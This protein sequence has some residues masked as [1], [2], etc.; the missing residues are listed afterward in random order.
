[1]IWLGLSAV[2]RERMFR[3]PGTL[4]HTVVGE[5]MIRAGEVIR[6][7]P[8]SFTFEG[9]TWIAHQWLAECAMALAH[10]AAGLDGLLLV[11]CVILAATYAAVGQRLIRGGMSFAGS[12]AVI[13]LLLGAS[14]F[15]FHARPHILTIAFSAWIFALLCDV[16]AG[17]RKLQSMWAMPLI[18]GLWANL[19]GGALGGLATV[20]VAIGGWAVVSLALP[21]RTTRGAAMLTGVALVSILA[22]LVN[23]YGLELPRVW[24]QLMGSSVLPRVM[25]EHGPLEPGS[26]AGMMILAVAALYL[27]MLVTS[28]R[29]MLRV[30]WLIPLLWMY[31]AMSRVRHGP[32]FCVLAAIAVAE[33]LPYSSLVEGLRS[34]GSAFFR[35]ITASGENQLGTTAASGG[36]RYA[37]IFVVSMVFLIQRGGIQLP[38][39]GA[40]W[41]RLSPAYWPVE[42]TKMLQEQSRESATPPRVFNQMIYGGYLI[43]V[44]PESRVFIDDRCELYGDDF[45]LNYESTLREPVRIEAEAVQWGIDYA[46]VSSRSAMAAHL[47][48]SPAWTAIH[49][50]P[51]AVVY[52]RQ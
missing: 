14:S 33:M 31:L 42:A 35:S 8:F 41:A 38:L 6:T 40:G 5:R 23:P 4:W 45:I 30:T 12:A 17:R 26:P 47:A 3:D 32:I 18:L 48:S 9:K 37:L 21:P 22:M 51:T 13:A 7:D 19:H 43:Y 29:H 16:E 25:H 39:V 46:I 27:V 52:R 44:M 34:R 10:R 1:M 2:G 50:D 49:K 28:R 24:L 11:A 15:H 20:M 36:V